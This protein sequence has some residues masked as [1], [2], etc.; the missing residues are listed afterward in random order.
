[1]KATAKDIVIMYKIGDK[2]HQVVTSPE[3]KEAI[4]ALYNNS[5]PVLEK[6]FCDI[7]T[8]NN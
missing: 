6:P 7:E 2:L 5:M 8:E 4:L 1:M 3:Q